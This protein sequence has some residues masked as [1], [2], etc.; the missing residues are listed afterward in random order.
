MRYL[1]PARKA[2]AAI[3]YAI[4]FQKE[5]IPIRWLYNNDFDYC[6]VRVN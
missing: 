4:S 1:K 6:L 2:A 3:Q 5:V